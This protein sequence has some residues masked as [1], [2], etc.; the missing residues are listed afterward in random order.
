[1]QTVWQLG[2]VTVEEAR[3][4]LPPTHRV[5]YTTVQTVLN[6]LVARGLAL[7]E[8]E[9]RSFRYRATVTEAEHLAHA[10]RHALCGASTEARETAMAKLIGA[11]EH[12]ELSRLKRRARAL[13]A[14]RSGT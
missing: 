9:G 13:E 3:E 7:R 1:M 5:A 10:I 2:S 8:L 12:G 6:R 11:L 14:R 4:A